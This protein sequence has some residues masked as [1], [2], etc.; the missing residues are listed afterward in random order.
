MPVKSHYEGVTGHQVSLSDQH[1]M[2]NSL[3]AEECITLFRL[4]QFVLIIFQGG[5]I[6]MQMSNKGP[7]CT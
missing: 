2:L 3:T 4:G 7:L 5:L 1:P 6:S